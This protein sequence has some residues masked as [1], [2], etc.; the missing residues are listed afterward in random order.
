M[1]NIEFDKHVARACRMRR[2]AIAG[3]V[4]AHAPEGYC[5]EACFLADRKRWVPA[6]T[7]LRL[8]WP[9]R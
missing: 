6:A 3:P 5:G 8:R 4:F 9:R 7:M 1:E 2:T